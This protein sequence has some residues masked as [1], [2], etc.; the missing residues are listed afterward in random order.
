L[1]AGEV[2]GAIVDSGPLIHLHEARCLPLLDVV[3]PLHAL[4]EVWRE[5]AAH[6]GPPETDLL[7]IGLGREPHPVDI[8]S[9]IETA[10]LGR[11]D[12][13]ERECL[14]LCRRLEIPILVTDDLAARD[15]ARRL[16]ITPAIVELA[17]A[18]LRSGK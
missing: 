13:G 17:I 10:D 4:E 16:S 14:R 3:A 15:A 7:S 1:G 12:R 2:A 6:G 18:Q 5:V 9:F 8:E 11:L